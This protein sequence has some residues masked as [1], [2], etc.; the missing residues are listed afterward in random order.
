MDLERASYIVRYFP[1]LMS[2]DERSAWWHHFAMSKIEQIPSGLENTEAQEWQRSKIE[3]YKGQNM[4]SQDAQVLG[5]LENG[6]DEFVIAT[7]ERVMQEEPAEIFFNDCPNCDALARTPQSKQCRHCGFSW[8]ERVGATF[9]HK[10]S[11]A[12]SGKPYSIVFEGEV[13]KG[14]VSPGMLVD[15]TYF[16]I[17]LKAEIEDVTPLGLEKIN[18]DFEISNDEIRQLLI[19]AG[20]NIEPINIE[21]NQD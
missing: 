17:N 7:A 1:R 2:V 20:K 11:R 13:E 6:Y 19:E 10:L 16:G 14:E 3:F 12:H 15:L 21:F 4:V 8:H 18:F 9:R 5:L